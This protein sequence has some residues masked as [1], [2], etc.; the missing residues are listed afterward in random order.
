MVPILATPIAL[1]A[2][3]QPPAF[4]LRF[5]ET[6]VWNP[7]TRGPL[8]IVLPGDEKSLQPVNFGSLTGFAP[9]QRTELLWEKLPAPDLY[10]SLG[11]PEKFGILQAS[12]SEQ[13]WEKLCSHAGLGLA[14]LGRDQRTL[15]LALL[16]APL[17]L[18]RGVEVVQIKDPERPRARLRLSRKFTYRFTNS[19]GASL[20][21]SSGEAEAPR[22]TL[23]QPAVRLP[24]YRGF[25]ESLP[26]NVQA[27]FSF[28]TT[29][30]DIQGV[31]L[32]EGLNQRLSFVNNGNSSG[33]SFGAK[34]TEPHNNSAKPG[35]LD[36]AAAVLDVRV[37]LIGV[38]TVGEL[39]KR[40]A[41]AT[42]LELFCD[43]RYAHRPLHMRGTSARAGDISQALA[44]CLTGT[45]R[46][47]GPG[48]VLTDDLVP[49]A[50]RM[51]RIQDWLSAAQAELDRAREGTGAAAALQAT[52]LQW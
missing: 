8:L 17:T 42:K 12:L 31:T 7:E 24:V 2:Q 40:C 23:G 44:R 6:F 16:P 3:A 15:F 46:K 47:V 4:S 41:D 1:T 34:F 5:P 26:T 36:F 28:V 22:W 13:Q 33:G 27:E 35:Q 37:S 51:G 29:L 49:L 18:S 39:V 52:Y 50:I 9:K 20:A 38:Q 21:L 32:S 19:S 25:T 10:S 11:D 43:P 45:W 30:T 48:F 14:D